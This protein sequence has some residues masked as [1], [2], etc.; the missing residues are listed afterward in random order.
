MYFSQ[1]VAGE[2]PQLRDYSQRIYDLL[3]EYQ[4]VNPSKISVELIDPIA[5]SDAEDE[6]TLAGLRSAPVSL[7]GETLFLGLIAERTGNEEAREVIEFF[8]PE[9][10]RF[11]EYDVSQVIYKLGK[12]KTPSIGVFSDAPLFGGY[13]GFGMQQSAPWTVITQLQQI[14][15]VSPV[16]ATDINEQ[17]DVLL[18]VHPESV[19]EQ[20]LYAIEQYLL[21]GGRALFFV[22]PN[23]EIL[24]QG[25]GGGSSSALPQL[26]DQWGLEYNS[27]AVVGDLTWGL[28]IPVD[29]T[30][31]P[32]PHVGIMG[33]PAD[34]MDQDSIITTELETI[35]VAS[36]GSLLLAEDSPLTWTPLLQ[37]TTNA[38][39][40]TR[41]EYTAAANHG[42]LL[43]DYNG[44]GKRLVLAAKISGEV[45]ASFSEYPEPQQT[46]ESESDTAGDTNLEQNVEPDQRPA[47]IERGTINA[48]VVADVDLLSDRLWVQVSNLFGQRVVMPWANNGDFLLNAVENLGGSEALISLR[49]RGQYSRP[50][51]V[52]NQLRNEAAEAFKQEEQILLERLKVLEES[53]ASVNAPIDGQ[54]EVV[55]S[56][57]QEQEIERF[58]Q[59]RLDTRKQLRQVQL[60][61]NQS[62]DALANRLRWLNIGLMPILLLVTM[63]GVMILRR[64][65]AT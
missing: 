22:D 29:E 58:E 35:N 12:Q 20:A 51:T 21:S 36:S 44:D 34:A 28:R 52:V 59:Q 60:Q 42:Q 26:F 49:S 45:S 53:I 16:L 61:L 17:L 7:G 32:L 1:S 6:A 37:T 62:I 57:E 10:E 8:N 41:E 3:L 15:S 30:S 4:E 2:L 64:R 47:H 65:S 11:L 46:T 54:A 13:G 43:V 9:R 25:P 39:Q 40:F 55:L 38:K 50:F 23:A 56:P 19:S 5:F 48:I 27:D 63:L 14:A 18:V 31:A 24:A 33:L